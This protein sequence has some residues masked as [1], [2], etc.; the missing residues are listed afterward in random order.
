[1]S[2]KSNDKA[3]PVVSGQSCDQL[4][5]SLAAPHGV[6]RSA[7]SELG[8][9]WVGRLV[10]LKCETTHNQVSDHTWQSAKL[11]RNKFVPNLISPCSHDIYGS[12]LQTSSWSCSMVSDEIVITNRFGKAWSYVLNGFMFSNFY[13]VIYDLLLLLCFYLWSCEPDW[14]CLSFTW[15]RLLYSILL[16]LLCVRKH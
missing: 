8:I 2:D 16:R 11:M 1:M 14:L 4:I 9:E 13:V 3:I 7:E 5:E 6:A 12:L 15:N 10:H